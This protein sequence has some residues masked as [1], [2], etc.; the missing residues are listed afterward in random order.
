MN[1]FYLKLLAVLLMV[2]DHIGFFLYPQYT[3]L[4]II[5]RLSFPIFGFLIANGYNYTR[6]KKKYFLRL[7]I[8]AN[9]IQIPSLFTTIP[10]NIFYTLS[11]G[12]LCIMI[13][14][15]VYDEV[16]KIVGIAGILVITLM[17]QPDYSIYGV[18]LIFII[19]LLKD[20]YIYMIGAFLVLSFV[21]Y[22]PTSIQGFA[23]LTPLIFMTYNH[24]KGRS[25]KYLFYLFYPVHI[26]FLDWLSQRI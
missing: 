19:H 12:L 9:I 3:I 5:G 18:L 1:T 20:N 6:D 7:F 13:F 17:I 23:A 16:N 14:E 26:V 4:R 21:L 15:S 25:M 11:F 22:G 8:F 2:V 24:Q 10:V